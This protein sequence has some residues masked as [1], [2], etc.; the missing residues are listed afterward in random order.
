MIPLVA[1]VMLAKVILR[2]LNLLVKTLV[3]TNTRAKRKVLLELQNALTPNLLI[4]HSPRTLRKL[5]LLLLMLLIP[6]ICSNNQ[7]VTTNKR[8]LLQV[9]RSK[10]QVC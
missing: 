5:L 3:E 9:L 6:W 1:L 10:T 4:Y 7:L 8:F 2:T